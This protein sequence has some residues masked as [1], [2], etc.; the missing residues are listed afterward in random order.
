MAS[1]TDSIPKYNPYISQVPYELM[2][3]VG[4]AKQQQYEQGIQK[5]QSTIDNVAG[6]DIYKDV[7]KQYLQSKL[8]QLGNDLKWVG[9]SD[10]SD[11]Q[12]VNSVNGMTNQ[13]VK[14]KNVLN[15]VSSTAFAKKEM[16]FMEEERKKG[17]TSPSNEAV[18]NEKLNSW[19]NDG[20]VGSSFSG[21][22][23]P[24]FDVWK[25]AKDT[26]DALGDESMSFDQIYQ[27]D[28]ATKRPLL[29]KNNKPILSNHM[30]RMIKEGKFPEKVKVTLNQIF[31][32]PRVGKQLSIDGQYNLSGLD[33]TALKQKI[34]LK[35]E[36]DLSSYEDRLF[37]LQMAKSFGKDVSGEI[38]N[39]KDSIT[40]INTSY[41]DLL[42]SS[43]LKA[44]RGTLY[45]QDT[46][47]RYTGMFTKIKVTEQIL[48]NPAAKFEF[49]L[50]KEAQRRSEKAFDQ[51]LEVLK[52]KRGILES[53]RDY[54]LNVFKAQTEAN[55][56]GGASKNNNTGGGD[57]GGGTNRPEDTTRQFVA[58]A[59]EKY[60]N[61]ANSYSSAQDKFI[62]ETMFKSPANEETIKQIMKDAPGDTPLSQGAAIGLFLKLQAK[63][64]KESNGDI[65]VFRTKWALLGKERMNN[66]ADKTKIN[67][68]IKDIYDNTLATRKVFD[69]E[70]SN[71]IEREKDAVKTVESLGLDE[72]F[73]NIQPE[74][75]T[76]RG[77][78]VTL[79]KQNQIDIATYIAGKHNIVPM[80]ANVSKD[81]ANQ[82]KKRLDNQGLGDIAE[83]YLQ[84][85]R[86]AD[87][88]ANPI[89]GAVGVVA[90]IGSGIADVF[91]EGETN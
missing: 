16:A 89:S 17:K 25:Y 58:M 12:L 35:K 50:N 79:S 65:S 76:Y 21:K 61:A 53:D 36:N 83:R 71:R 32:D 29:D 11:F 55:K 69:L 5:I 64:D 63:K 74:T 45:K 68:V 39:V 19:A 44:I 57:G 30:V 91:S 86:V 51:N 4:M 23:D 6:L 24:Y 34:Q 75:V 14:D 2:A 70:N 33:E 3:K 49:D 20:K 90:N 48:D 8:N 40:K 47:D 38:D 9:A 18:F 1:F 15:A 26:F 7:D 82:A 62:W 42:G 10:F 78:K 56:K 67:P 80:G 77:Q 66:T 27:T 85:S 87:I 13:L 41:D 52:Y 60:T 54:E 28:P 37:D 84:S 88:P 22:Y 31:S 59:D 46:Y 43:D 73:A 72:D 81:I